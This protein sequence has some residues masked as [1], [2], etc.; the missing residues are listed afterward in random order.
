MHIPVIKEDL[1]LNVSLLRQQSNY[2]YKSSET[3][4]ACK[5]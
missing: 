2:N 5:L 3:V 1:N 4:I